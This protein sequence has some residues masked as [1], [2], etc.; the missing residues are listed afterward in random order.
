MSRYNKLEKFAQT[1]QFP[2]FFEVGFYDVLESDSNLK[3]KWNKD[4]FKNENDIVVEFGCGKGEYSYGLAKKNQ[5]KNFIGVDIKGARM[6]KGAKKSFE[7]KMTNIAFVRTRVEF[8][9]KCFDKN[10]ISE[11]WITFPDPQLRHKKRIKKRL[12]SSRFL[13]YYR[14]FL[15]NNGIIH[16]KTDDDTLY[17]YTKSV[18]ELNNLKI[19][20]DTDD[21]YNSDYDNDILSIK[22]F[23]E[24]MWLA[25]GKKIKY[26]SFFL[27]NNKDIIEPEIVEGEY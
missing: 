24:K 27:E 26:I 22:T 1:K 16:L 11:I 15:K 3:G 25:E 8:T 9:P 7:E 5:N 12:T 17:K 19:L 13:N 4:F 2:H 10:E 21:L 6:W 23:Y 14:N 18:V 20:V